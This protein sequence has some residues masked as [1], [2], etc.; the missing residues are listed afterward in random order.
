MPLDLFSNTP[1][2]NTPLGKIEETIDNLKESH[3]QEECLKKTYEILSTKYR[4]YRIKT[5]TRLFDIFERDIEKLWN[6]EGFLHCTNINYLM[7]VLLMR[8]GCFT[9]DD[10]RIRW[11]QI[12][13]ISPHQ[14]L[15]VR[16]GN[17]WID[18]DI[19]ARA[20]GI[21]FGD[22]AHGFH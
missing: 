17:K 1:I 21:P 4:G 6:K 5:Y 20:Y 12:W 22:H 16:I 11:T 19:W 18:V 7:R 10:I 3:N 15:Q 8:S 14:Y 2:P 13:L 9:E